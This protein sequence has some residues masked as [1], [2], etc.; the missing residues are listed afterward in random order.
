MNI[1]LPFL[2]TDPEEA[3]HLHYVGKFHKSD[4]LYRCSELREQYIPTGSTGILSNDI[5]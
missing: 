1:N 3:A 5:R 2:S 4:I